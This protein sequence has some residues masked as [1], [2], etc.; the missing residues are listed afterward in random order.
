MDIPLFVYSF[1]Y[2]WTYFQFLTNMNEDSLLYVC[3]SLYVHT[4]KYWL[5]QLVKGTI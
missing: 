3:K 5:M 4:Q 2:S 1:I